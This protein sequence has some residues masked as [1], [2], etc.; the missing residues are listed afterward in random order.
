MKGEPTFISLCISQK[1]IEA[2]LFDP[3]EKFGPVDLNDERIFFEFSM[4]YQCM[5]MKHSASVAGPA[6]FGVQRVNMIREEKL[7]AGK[8]TG[9]RFS[10]INY[11]MS[12]VTAL[13]A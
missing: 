12:I 8:A 2:Q 5:M 3:L 10:A 7:W 6:F 9:K 1:K 11:E 4:F 13:R